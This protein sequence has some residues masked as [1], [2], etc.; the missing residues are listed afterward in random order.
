[1]KHVIKGTAP[2][3]FESWK[4]TATSEWTPSY[5]ELREPERGLLHNALLNEQAWVC[6]YC[7]RQIT[8]DDSHIEHFRP[9][10]P[11]VELALTYE[12]LHA[13][14]IRSAERNVLHC[15]HAKDK[16]FDEGLHISP[17]DSKCESRFL[18]TANGRVIALDRSDANAL[19]MIELLKLNH[20]SL[21]SR[22]SD[23]INRVFNPT[24]LANDSPE[25]IANIRDA[26]RVL[27]AQGHA[28]DFGHV[29]ARV[30]EQRLAES[31]LSNE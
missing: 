12:N 3:S 24:A 2:A 11:H 10:R 19:Y 15:G 9:Q 23:A 31:T 20:A 4:T 28:L 13:S 18:Y 5:S 30:A 1:M 7:G 8:V 25:N 17:L 6:C 14:C 22:R 27:D 29:L 21:V 16:K 26:Q